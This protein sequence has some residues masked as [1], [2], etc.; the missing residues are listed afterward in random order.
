[1]MPEKEEYG[2]W[3]RSGEIDIVESRGNDVDYPSGGR[4]TCS[5]TI[6]WGTFS[7][8]FLPISFLPDGFLLLRHAKRR[9]KI[10]AFH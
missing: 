4:D 7:I 6:H 5:S 2:V 9:R 3:P 1:M 8:S 10:R